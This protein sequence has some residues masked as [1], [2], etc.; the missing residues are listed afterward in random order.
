MSDAEALGEVFAFFDADG[1]GQVDRSELEKIIAKAAEEDGI[2]IKPDEVAE[3]AKLFI[4]SGDDNNDG[5]L[6]K[7]EFIRLMQEF[8]NSK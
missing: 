4:D 3:V 8:I 1:S 6:S 7:A 5:K 2:A